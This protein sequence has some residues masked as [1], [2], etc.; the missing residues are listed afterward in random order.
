VAR[1]PVAA[2]FVH[3]P[4]RAWHSVPAVCREAVPEAVLRPLV[5]AAHL[6]GTAKAAVPRPAALPEAA[7]RPQGEVV[8][9]AAVAVEYRRQR[10]AARPVLTAAAHL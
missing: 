6:W 9:A 3:R 10:A 5:A 1:R 8:A 7:L 4:A 2:R